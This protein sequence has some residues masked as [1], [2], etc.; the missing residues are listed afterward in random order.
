MTPAPGGYS[1][2]SLQ[3]KACLFSLL[4]KVVLSNGRSVNESGLHL[5]L[6]YTL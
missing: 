1:A 3:Q 2:A 4:V 5:Y 6:S